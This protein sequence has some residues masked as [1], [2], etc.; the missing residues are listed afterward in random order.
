MIV[1]EE[2]FEALPAGE[3]SK[4][5]ARM[6]P[7]KPKQRTPLAR[8]T[9]ESVFENLD[10]FCQRIAYLDH[11]YDTLHIEGTSP[12]ILRQLILLR[13]CHV[14]LEQFSGILDMIQLV[15]STFREKI[16]DPRRAIITSSRLEEITR[17]AYF[18]E[19]VRDRQCELTLATE[20]LIEITGV[21]LADTKSYRLLVA[22][23]R[24]TCAD[25]LSKRCLEF[26][27]D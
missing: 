13:F 9:G 24:A 17:D 14:S 25:L 27:L 7:N 16:S 20:S 26:R 1:L 21:A 12:N 11:T 19:Q 18:Y 15:Y 22:E 6:R 5:L 4:L 2:I 8:P 23:I 10:A 3:R